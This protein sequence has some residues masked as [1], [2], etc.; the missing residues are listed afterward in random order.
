MVTLLSS[1]SKR[2]VPLHW[3][4]VFVTMLPV[5]VMF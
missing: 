2:R 1:P 3:S 5:M 4:W